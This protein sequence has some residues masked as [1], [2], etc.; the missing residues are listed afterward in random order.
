MKIPRPLVAFI[1]FA[2]VSAVIATPVYMR[3]ELR[4]RSS[5]TNSPPVAV[6]DSYT[7]HGMGTIGPL[8][9]NDSDP[10]GDQIFGPDILSFP[11]HGTLS[12]L[13]QPDL[14]SYSPN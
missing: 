3:A 13:P 11:A 1:G 8:F 5:A 7:V 9:A 6:D 4:S 12:G 2:V 14:K 10:D